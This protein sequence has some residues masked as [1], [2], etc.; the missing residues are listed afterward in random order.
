MNPRYIPFIVDKRQ[1][2]PGGSEEDGFFFSL[3]LSG[4][5][6]RGSG[7]RHERC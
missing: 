6:D 7:M 5:D 2:D 1:L 4:T 3:I